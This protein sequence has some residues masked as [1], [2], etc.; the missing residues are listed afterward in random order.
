MANPRKPKNSVA[1]FSEAKDRSKL[2]DIQLT[3]T[4]PTLQYPFLQDESTISCIRSTKVMFVMRGFP[5]SGK[6]TLAEILAYLYPGAVICSADHFFL[7]NGSFHW[8]PKR[9]KD[10]HLAC[11]KRAEEA[12]QSGKVIIVDNSNI[13]VWEMQFYL[14]LANDFSYIT[15][16]VEPK[17]SWRKELDQLAARTVHDVTSEFIRRKMEE[18]QVAIPLYFGWFLNERDSN[19]LL[20]IARIQLQQCIRC[21]EFKKWVRNLTPGIACK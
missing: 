11:Q 6:T 14:N 19:E 8:N 4:N 13:K 15:V 17:T 10:A 18:Y 12:C 9:W 16:L 2:P 21:K 5:G 3:R 7:R 20:E 1:H